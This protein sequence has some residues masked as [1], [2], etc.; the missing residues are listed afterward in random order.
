MKPLFSTSYLLFTSKRNIFESSD[1]LN[2]AHDKYSFFPQLPIRRQVEDYLKRSPLHNFVNSTHVAHC[3]TRKCFFYHCLPMLWRTREF[4]YSIQYLLDSQV[5]NKLL[6]KSV[7]ALT[8]QMFYIN[9][10]THNF[11][12]TVIT[13]TVYCTEIAP[14]LFV[15][16]ERF[17][18][19]D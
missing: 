14:L 18:T 7:L 5:H 4:R 10:Q 8:T 9:I 6:W 1:C 2:Y 3:V 16:Q 15:L 11:Y 19:H 12:L 17:R 13:Y